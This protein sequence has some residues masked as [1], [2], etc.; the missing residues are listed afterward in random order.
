MSNLS[1]RKDTDRRGFLRKLVVLTGSAGIAGVLLD[2]LIGKSALAPVQAT[3]GSSGEA[4]IIDASGPGSL[5]NT[6]TGTTQLNSSGTPALIAANTGSGAALEGSC[7]AGTGVLGTTTIGTGVQGTASAATGVAVGGFAGDPGAIP[8]VAQG[9][10]SQT[11]NL[12]E[13]RGSSGALSVV[14]A[15]GQIGV[16]T[17][18][19]SPVASLEVAGKVKVSSGTGVGQGALDAASSTLALSQDYWTQAEMSSHHTSGNP[20]FVFYRSE[21]TR[22]SPAAVANGDYVGSLFSRAYDGTQYSNCVGIRFA[23]DGTPGAGSLPS[24]ITFHTSPS[25]SATLTERMRITSAGNVGIGT[26][27]ASHLIQLSGGAYSN[28]TSW[29]SVSSVRWKENIEPLTDGVETLRQLHPV[30]F[31][32]KKMPAKRTM[33]FIAEE[34]GKVLPTIVDWD[35][36]EPGYA[37]GYDQLAILALA[38]QA[39]KTLSAQVEKLQ[40]ELAGL[41]ESAN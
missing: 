34:V 41:K 38:V 18:T 32:Y 29:T 11:A 24:R 27:S 26:T 17:G 12:Q 37:E 15:N 28:G 2:R 3:G 39:I 5:S 25:G 13:W 35:N 9:A 30:S 8:I 19:S 36:A 14:D 10:S 23:I 4:L 33:G 7:T 16:G 21:G 31:N 22:T 40:A 1:E 6:G 20:S